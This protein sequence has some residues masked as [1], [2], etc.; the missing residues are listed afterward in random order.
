MHYHIN[1]L[2]RLAF[3]RS[4]P[5]IFCGKTV[6]I[7]NHDNT[8]RVMLTREFTVRLKLQLLLLW[9][10]IKLFAQ[11]RQAFYLKLIWLELLCFPSRVLGQRISSRS[12]HWK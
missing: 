7:G 1:S 8:T 6:I 4:R 2:G 5:G 10:K 3:L 9:Q 11:Y 12:L